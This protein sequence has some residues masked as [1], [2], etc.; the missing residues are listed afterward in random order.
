MYGLYKGIRLRVP[1][2]QTL[3]EP[4]EC[5]G[6]S[7]ARTLNQ[8]IED[9]RCV[10]GMEFLRGCEPCSL[11]GQPT[12]SAGASGASFEVAIRILS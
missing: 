8:N 2:K 7:V 10:V 5:L 12:G 1:S 6:W 11:D 4:L 9:V 3:L